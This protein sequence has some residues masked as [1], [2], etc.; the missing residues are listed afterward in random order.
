MQ[1]AIAA[2][3]LVTLVALQ[4]FQCMVM[5]GA[6]FLTADPRL[7]C[8]T[9]TWWRRAAGSV[10]VLVLFGAG[11]PLGVV[12]VLAQRRDRLFGPVSASTRRRFGFL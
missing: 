7:L 10:L 1:V 9:H 5:A 4:Q 11:L 2:H 12:G 6:H 3:P 8:Y